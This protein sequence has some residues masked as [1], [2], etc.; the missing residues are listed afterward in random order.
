[1]MIVNFDFR[2]LPLFRH[3]MSTCRTPPLANCRPWAEVT[4]AARVIR[5]TCRRSWGATGHRMS[6]VL[7]GWSLIS[8]QPTK[9]QHKCVA[10]CPQKWVT[11]KYI[12]QEK[13]LFYVVSGMFLRGKPWIFLALLLQQPCR[14]P[15]PSGPEPHGAAPSSSLRISLRCRT[16]SPVTRRRRWS[17]VLH[18]GVSEVIGGTPRHHPYHPCSF[19][20]GGGSSTKKNIQ[21]LG[22]P[23]FW[24]PPYVV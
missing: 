6:Q 20:W 4:T 11:P 9:S 24:K 10:V 23:H 2:H 7:F 13:T 17:I 3:R 8:K 22:Y 21:L 12:H 15:P 16:A 1:M 5:F 14:T 19:F 18:M